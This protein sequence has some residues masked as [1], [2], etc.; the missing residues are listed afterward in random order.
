MTPS[1]RISE[2]SIEVPGSPEQVWEAIA[3]GPGISAW[4]V[5]AE[6]DEREGGRI[7][8]H[9]GRIDPEEEP[10][11]STGEISAWEPP[12]R[13]AYIERWQ[14]DPNATEES[15]ATEFL[16][17]ARAGGT[18]L[19]R[20]ITSGFGSGKE[21]D[22]AIE[23]LERGWPPYLRIL[24][25]H[26]AHFAGRRGAPVRVTRLVDE[27]VAEAGPRLLSALGMSGAAEGERI[28]LAEGAPPLAGTVAG[29]VAD[30]LLLRL[31]EPAPGS[32]IF[33]AYPF[34][35]RTIALAQLHL[36]GDDAGAIAAREKPRWQDWIETRLP[37]VGEP[38][39]PRAD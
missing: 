20:L 26:L 7:A 24:R 13:F 21:W 1:E 5:P 23:D 35:E 12:H 37:A 19:V 17:E 38:V 11:E 10:I 28:G 29:R 8:L 18:C 2:L 14:P 36:Y 31:D 22:D 34:G 27:P 30:E 15:V 33:G 6:V 4:F 9:F 32:A 25:L 16:V 39:A 3:T